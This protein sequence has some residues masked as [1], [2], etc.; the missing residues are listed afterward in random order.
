[1]VENKFKKYV[2]V[3]KLNADPVCVVHSKQNGFY[4]D[5]LEDCGI[6]HDAGPGECA[7]V[8]DYPLK[9]KAQLHN[10]TIK[11]YYDLQPGDVFTLGER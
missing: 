7:W 6:W 4:A 11:T 9:I 5:I 2:F 10:G 1:M 3:C 8:V